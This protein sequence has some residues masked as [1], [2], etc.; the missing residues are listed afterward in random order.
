MSKWNCSIFLCVFSPAIKIQEMVTHNC[1]MVFSDR[2]LANIFRIPHT[3][4][5]LHNFLNYSTFFYKL[6]CKKRYLRIFASYFNNN[7]HTRDDEFR[8]IWS[9]LPLT[10]P[11]WHLCQDMRV[12]SPAYRG[13]DSLPETAAVRT[14]FTFVPS[15]VVENRFMYSFV[16]KVSS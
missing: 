11:I 7:K 1:I 15:M 2:W 4:Y 12:G 9:C 6:T 8:A 10:V 16:A 3:C 13:N 14:V 5:N